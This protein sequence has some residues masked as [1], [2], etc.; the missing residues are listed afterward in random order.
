MLRVYLGGHITEIE[1][2]QFFHDRFKNN[3]K[4]ELLDPIE[5]TNHLLEKYGIAQEV[6]TTETAIFPDELKVQ[7]VDHD[8][9]L[10][11]E[12][13]ILVAYIEKFTAGTLMEILYA[14]DKKDC[15]VLI[16]NPGLT[17]KN[18]VWLW[19][20]QDSMFDNMEE[21]AKY[22]EKISEQKTY[23]GINIS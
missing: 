19:Y 11:G 7:I 4:I 20:H 16:I 5:R 17:F 1:Y 21:C 14:F 18:D 13:H 9:K 23:L 3:K 15:T 2:R 12:C 8:K 10:I 22:I 6:H